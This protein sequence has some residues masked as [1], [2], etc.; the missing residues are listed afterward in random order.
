MRSTTGAMPQPGERLTLEAVELLTVRAQR[1]G[2]WCAAQVRVSI[3]GRA[4][5][6]DAT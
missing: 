2:G 4:N 1:D 6:V 5:I 3:K